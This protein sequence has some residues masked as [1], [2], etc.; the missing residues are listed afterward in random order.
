MEA[1][2]IGILI[3]KTLRTV[4][5]LYLGYHLGKW[6]VDKFKKKSKDQ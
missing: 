3:G 4:F 2:E 6:L 1:F 5:L